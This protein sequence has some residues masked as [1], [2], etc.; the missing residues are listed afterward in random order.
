MP[1]PESWRKA[2]KEALDKEKEN[3][4]IPKKS[5]GK[6][7]CN[8]SCHEIC[9]L[10]GNPFIGSLPHINC[11]DILGSESSYSWTNNADQ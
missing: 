11:A 4:G 6:V 10:C 9:H 3:Y 5:N 7:I 8:C 2:A 1:T